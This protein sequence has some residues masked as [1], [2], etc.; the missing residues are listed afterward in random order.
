MIGYGVVVWLHVLAAA[1]WIGSMVFFAAVVVPVVRKLEPQAAAP[2][3]RKIGVRFR[4]LGWLALSALVV[5]GAANLFYRG[6]TWEMLTSG[7]FWS[8][9]FG[10]VLG[11]KLGLVAIILIATALHDV[12]ASSPVRGRLGSA[13]DQQL[14]RR[15]ASWLGRFVMVVSLVILFLAVALA[16][17]F[18]S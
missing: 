18:L 8:A 11:W 17:G 14:A 9:G 6:V 5:T 16:R 12:L 2:L 1:V 4:A 10:L 15:R 7:A 13:R 3:I